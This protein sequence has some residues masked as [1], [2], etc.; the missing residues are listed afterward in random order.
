MKRI[1]LTSLSLLLILTSFSQ[2]TYQVGTGNLAPTITLYGPIYRYSASTTSDR[3]RCNILYTQAELALAGVLPGTTITQ[4]EWNKINAG[5]ST[6]PFSFTILMANTSNTSLSI[7]ESWTNILNTHT[8]VFTT[9]SQQINAATGWVPFTLQTPFVYT[10]G[11]LE[12]AT[13]VDFTAIVGNPATSE[14]HWEYTDLL[15]DQIIST[16][17]GTAFNTS[18]SATTAVYKQRPNIRITLA[19]VQSEDAAISVLNS[20]LNFCG[21]LLPVNVNLVNVGSN[22]L[23]TVNIN[24]EING[25]PQ[26]PVNLT[27]M[28]LLHG[29]DSAVALGN[30]LFLPNVPYQ[31]KAWVSQPNGVADMNAVN[32]TLLQ[33]VQSSLSGNFT[34][35]NTLPPSATNFTSFN[36]LATALHTYGL[37]GPLQVDVAPGT[38][39]YNEQV[40]FNAINGSS[41]VNTVSING[42]GNLLTFAPTVSADR[43]IMRFIGT[44]YFNID[45]LNVTSTGTHGFGYH[46]M[47]NTHHV[48]IRN[49]VVTNINSSTSTNYAGIVASSS[50]TSATT[51]GNSA[52]YVTLENNR[53]IGG[54]YGIVLTGDG[55]NSTIDSN[56]VRNNII[57][58]PYSSGIY[59][60]GNRGTLVSGNDISR[61]TRST[62]TTF[63]GVNLQAGN[64]GNRIEKN[65]IHNTSDGNTASTSA[66]YGLYIIS[67]APGNTD[68]NIFANNLVYKMTNSGVQNGLLLSSNVDNVRVYHNTIA[69]NDEAA[70]GGDTRGIYITP[71]VADLDI[72]NNIIYITRGGPD[73]KEAVNIQAGTPTIDYNVY[74][75]NSLGGNNF[76]G[77]ENSQGYGTFAAWQAANGGTY[78]QNS[79]EADPIFLAP[80]SGLFT[81]LNFNFD[82][83][84][85]NLLSIVPDDFIGIPRTTTP[86]PGAYE[87]APS[88]N[89]AG[90]IAL[91]TPSQVYCTGVNPVSVRV[92]AFGL[93]LL[94][95]VTVNWEVNGVLQTPLSLTN[96]NMPTATDTI[97]TLGNFNFLAGNIYNIKAWTSQPNGVTDQFVFNDTLLAPGLTN[98][99]QGTYT[100]NTTLPPSPTNYNSFSG[101]VTDLSTRGVCGPV[102]FE[103]APGT[104]PG[105]VTINTVFGT[106]PSNTVTFRA[107]NLDSTSVK[108]TYFAVGTADNYVVRVTSSNY[109]RFE[110][111]TIEAQGT[112]YGRGLQING[113]SRNILITNCIVASD[114]NTTTE[115]STVNRAAIFSDA[116][117]ND[118]IVIRNNHIKG[119]SYGILME[120]VSST[121]RETGLVIENNTFTRLAH[122]G[123]RIAYQDNPT[124][125]NN[126]MQ[127]SP[128]YTGSATT[129]GYYLLDVYKGFE[130]ESNHILTQGEHPNYGIYLSSVNGDLTDRG[131]VSNNVISTGAPGVTATLYGIYATAS[132]RM[133]IEHNSIRVH[134]TGTSGSAFFATNTGSI[135]FY[136]NNLALVHGGQVIDVDASF[137]LNFSDN[138][139]IWPG[140]NGGFIGEFIGTDVNSLASWQAVTGWEMNSISTDPLFSNDTT[141]RTCNPLLDG[142]GT[143]AA[144]SIIDRDGDIRNVNS[145]DIGADEFTGTGTFSLGPDI[146]KCPNDTVTLAA[147]DIQ[148]NTYF[149]NT[150]DLTPSITTSTPGNYIL[151]LSSACGSNTDTVLVQNEPSPTAAFTFQQSFLGFTFTNNS[152]NGTSYLW[153]FGDG[154]TSTQQNPIHFYTN[155]GPYTVTL[156]TYNVCGDS[157]VSTQQITIAILGEESPMDEIQMALYPNPSNGNFT[158]ELNLQQDDTALIE[159]LDITG[160]SIYQQQLQVAAGMNQLP[161]SLN[162]I[163][164]GTYL[165]RLKT[166][167]KNHVVRLI[168]E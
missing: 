165:L 141:L 131:R 67:S 146:T 128:I 28:N 120:G 90:V 68:P 103:M 92:G 110:H 13:E 25:T 12:I 41:S 95:D 60:N 62:V 21:G 125:R 132:G 5:A 7:T 34:I 44:S 11:S 138:N 135:N 73:V 65:R 154:N 82:N 43:H 157:A 133:D 150:L 139:N 96:L 166:S 45:S 2:T 36:S 69:L 52:N 1:V 100:I 115:S 47:N 164:A 66:N 27:G 124:V 8:Q 85:T 106:S 79:Q 6:G 30:F 74:Y 70:I 130:M 23:N 107:A 32:D 77:Y 42:H 56:I 9:T 102:V 49:S 140:T 113:N 53:I 167:T 89:D 149:W 160:K 109:I 136:N 10:G 122:Y 158:L 39:P 64:I 127:W 168:I 29:Q 71:A 75:V 161:V 142:T 54:Y 155:T 61:A 55:N 76:I 31:I 72:K 112:S 147:E 14:F 20:P 18:L 137:N 51:L 19:P 17:P 104:Y 134:S 38:G 123:M 162:Q 143:P 121:N 111:L 33:N 91:V 81:P 3:N 58:D 84:G 78:D 16:T 119:S 50:T 37:C 4:V 159:I 40:V 148:G 26:T 63:Y 108:I 80:N 151:T 117:I 129:Y 152:S 163:A 156:I 98:A 145:P 59:L 87:F 153:D 57:E 114:T 97:V 94:Q 35:N 101:A 88:Q 116:D 48:S 24:W 93:A 105:N 15:G 144:V 118:S 86:D 99:L 126:V 83:M 22:T 46:L